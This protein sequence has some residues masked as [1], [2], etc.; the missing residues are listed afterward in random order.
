[1]E[2]PIELKIHEDLCNE[3]HELY[4]NKNADYGDSFRKV[5]EKIPNAILV[6]LNDKLNRLESLMNKSEDEQKV[7]NESIDDTLMD[8]ANYALLELVERRKEHIDYVK[9]RMEEGSGTIS[10]AVD[11]VVYAWQGFISDCKKENDNPPLTW[12][13]VQDMIGKPVWCSGNNEWCIVDSLHSSKSKQYVEFE[14]GNKF[15]FKTDSPIKPDWKL[16]RREKDEDDD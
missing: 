12:D 9:E 8:I 16:Y 2:Q 5:R 14:N 10:D 15:Y 4:M 7:K 13:D 3:I 11:A 1:M 6:R